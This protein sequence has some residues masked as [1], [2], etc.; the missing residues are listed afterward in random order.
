MAVV[1]ITATKMEKEQATVIPA[2]VAVDATDGAVVA[3]DCKD[4]QLYIILE[5][6]STSAAKVATIVNGKGLQGTG[7]LEQSIA[8]S[9]KTAIML[10]SGKYKQV[11]GT[12]KG[13]LWI[14]G[15][16]ANIKVAAMILP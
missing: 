12:H 15:A 5:N 3:W 13:K 9:G 16:D 10:D 2:T 14:K 1:T 11:S 7:D 6:A 4:A 8:A